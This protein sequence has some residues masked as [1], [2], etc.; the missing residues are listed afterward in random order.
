MVLCT[1]AINLLNCSFSKCAIKY[2]LYQNISN[3]NGFWH[4]SVPV[5]LQN[6]CKALVSYPKPFPKASPKGE[7]KGSKFV[8]KSKFLSSLI[9]GSFQFSYLSETLSHSFWPVY[10]AEYPVAKYYTNTCI[11]QHFSDIL[12]KACKWRNIY[13]LTWRPPIISI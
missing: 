1:S 9:Y 8:N 10:T 2:T 4:V 13:T 11:S 3:K 12:S 5:S 6:C 7:P